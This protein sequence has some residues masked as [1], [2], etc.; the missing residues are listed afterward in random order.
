MAD[1][2]KSKIKVIAGKPVALVEV[3]IKRTLIVDAEV[4]E[5]FSE[6]FEK[7][8]NDWTPTNLKG[9]TEF[10]KLIQN[11][12]KDAYSYINVP[13]TDADSKEIGLQSFGTIINFFEK[14]SYWR[15][16]GSSE[17]GY[18]GF[19]NLGAQDYKIDLSEAKIPEFIAKLDNNIL[20]YDAQI[21]SGELTPAEAKALK[22]A[23][24]I[25][26]KSSLGCGDLYKNFRDMLRER[27][28]QNKERMEKEIIDR[29]RTANGVSDYTGSFGEGG[30]GSD[31]GDMC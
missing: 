10:Y 13:W 4:Y 21:A 27:D 3:N 11:V 18:I 2:W 12:P 25:M 14:R 1:Q 8:N 31:V 15:V 16:E 29:D 28:R 19:F 6:F 24:E 7:G 30:H 5:R 20:E 22:D 23:C 17:S 9:V 26:K